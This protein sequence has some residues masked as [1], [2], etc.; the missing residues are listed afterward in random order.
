LFSPFFICLNPNYPSKKKPDN[1]D[2]PWYPTLTHKYKPPGPSSLEDMQV[3]WVATIDAFQSM[4]SKLRKATE[5]AVDLEHHSYRSYSGFLC[6]MQ[7]NGR[8]EDWLVDLLAL[9][10]EVESLNKVFTD[11]A[12][13][14]VPF[15]L[16][17][18]LTNLIIDFRFPWSG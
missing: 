10:D 8:E 7:I 18:L 13:V 6:L 2:S 17:Q 11:P 4:L 3:T 14:K 9:R 5:I 16:Y 12:I 1:L 15:Y